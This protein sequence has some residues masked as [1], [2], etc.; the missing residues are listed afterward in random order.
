MM[1]GAESLIFCGHI[2]VKQLEGVGLALAV[3]IGRTMHGA[4]E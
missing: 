4:I 2:G 3:S 1:L